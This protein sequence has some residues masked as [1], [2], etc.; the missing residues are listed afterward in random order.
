MNVQ[1]TARPTPLVTKASKLAPA[2]CD[3]HPQRS[4][5]KQLHP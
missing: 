1:V 4:N 5:D 2:D 3:I